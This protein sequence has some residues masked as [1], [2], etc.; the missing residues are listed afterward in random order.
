MNLALVK[1]PDSNG[2]QCDEGSTRHNW[3]GL[4]QVFSILVAF[5]GDVSLQ[6]APK[7]NASCCGLEKCRLN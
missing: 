6:T 4:I 2:K 7:V 1:V 5:H 3:N